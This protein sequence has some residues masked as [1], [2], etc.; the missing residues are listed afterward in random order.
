MINSYIASGN[1]IS[2][3]INGRPFVVER[4][5]PN[6]DDISEAA[7]NRKWSDIPDLMDVKKA[8]ESFL[9]TEAAYGDIT[10]NAV[11]ETIMY[12][13]EELHH[14]L[15]SHIFKL[16]EQNYSPMPMILFLH[17]LLQNPSKKAIDELYRW[18]ESNGITITDDGY[19]LAHKRVRD[20]YKSFFDG[21]TDNSIGSTPE[22]PRYQVDDRS[23]N[24]CSS[25][26]HFCSLSYLPSYHGGQG[27]ALIL[28]IN[29]ADVVSIPTDYGNAKGRACKYNIVGELRGDAR[30]T[31]EVKGAKPVLSQPVLKDVDVVNASRR[32]KDGYA[33]GYKAG[34]G[35]QKNEYKDGYPVTG[36]DFALGYINGYADGRGKSPQLYAQ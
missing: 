36:E 7:R 24:T 32:Y 8:V 11:T 28:K 22:M 9:I 13:G 34:R 2:M 27:R 16:M 18:M 4:D 17:N 30:A 23:D 1:Q 12:R 14:T 31:A 6:F 10:V 5:H 35:K 3:I 25:G 29:P 15:A 33:I 19:L 21:K 20:D 26:L